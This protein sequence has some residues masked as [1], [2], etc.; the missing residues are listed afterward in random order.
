MSAKHPLFISPDKHE[1]L[2][3]SE[4]KGTK[5][6]ST[7]SGS[8]YAI[9]DGFADLIYPLQLSDRE[10]TAQQFYDNRAGVYDQ[11]LYQTFKTHGENEEEV[12]NGFIDKLNINKNSKVLEIA[13]GTG[14]D[15]ELIAKRLGKDGQ[16]VMQDISGPMLKICR[17]K[18]ESFNINKEYCISNAAYLPFPDNYFDAT[19]SFGALG[20]FPEVKRSLKEMVRVTKN[21]GKIVVGDESMPPWLRDTYFSRVLTT[22]NP[23]F[24]AEVPLKDIPVDARKLNLQWVIGGVFYLIDFVVGDGE[25]VGDFDYEIEGPRGGTLR[26]RVEG[27]LEGVTKETKELAYQAARKKGIS[28]HQWLENLVKETAK[29]DLNS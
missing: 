27:Q 28:M 10:A 23:Q 4:S 17:E 15:S 20:E 9:K 29:K 7:K 12:R 24:A 19:Y 22:T 13:C 11:F 16:L 26:T 6:L 8:E 18:L 3:Q 2:F 5:V 21:G 1:E 14:R 25:P